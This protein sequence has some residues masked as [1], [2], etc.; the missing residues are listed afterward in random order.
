M[1]GLN[2]LCRRNLLQHRTQGDV[3]GAG[4]PRCINHPLMGN[5]CTAKCNGTG[6]NDSCNEE[7]AYF[8]SPHAYSPGSHKDEHSSS[9]GDAS[10]NM[11]SAINPSWS[12]R[13]VVDTNNGKSEV[14]S[15]ILLTTRL[16]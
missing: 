3:A 2:I 1:R 7:M 11:V 14:V 4:A 9:V 13:A 6:D 8:N 15:M 12:L 5:R 10:T 16:T